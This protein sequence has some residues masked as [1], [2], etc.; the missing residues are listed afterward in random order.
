M[1]GDMTGLRTRDGAATKKL[2]AMSRTQ[3]PMAA[4]SAAASGGKRRLPDAEPAKLVIRSYGLRTKSASSGIDFC[5]YAC[6]RC[7]DEAT[8]VA[9][10]RT[11][12][13]AAGAL[14]PPLA[15]SGSWPVAGAGVAVTGRVMVAVG[16]TPGG[17]VGRAVGSGVGVAVGVGGVAGGNVRGADDGGVDVADDPVPASAPKPATN[18]RPRPADGLTMVAVGFAAA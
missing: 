14:S 16:A 10:P 15:L 8:T 9:G 11:T 18:R 7:R 2:P 5:H 3:G 17:S 13:G 6:R 4:T 12:Q 1:P